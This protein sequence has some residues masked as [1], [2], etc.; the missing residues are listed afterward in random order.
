MDE[1]AAYLGSLHDR[2]LLLAHAPALLAADAPAAAKVRIHR[3]RDGRRRGWGGAWLLA[4][5]PR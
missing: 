3:S 5:A 4:S 2:A 1:I